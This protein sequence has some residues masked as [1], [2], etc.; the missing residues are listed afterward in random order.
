MLSELHDQE[1]GP[2]LVYA[3]SHQLDHVGVVHLLQ[4]A[5]GMSSLFVKGRVVMTWSGTLSLVISTSLH[6][7]PIQSY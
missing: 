2:G 4:E 6:P 1:D 3:G 7:S 5:E